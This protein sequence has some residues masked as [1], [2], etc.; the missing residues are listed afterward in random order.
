MNTNISKTITALRFPI[1][2]MVVFIHSTLS[3]N[4]GGVDAMAGGG[5]YVIHDYVSYGL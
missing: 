2:V 5:Y 1:C 3:V 4:I